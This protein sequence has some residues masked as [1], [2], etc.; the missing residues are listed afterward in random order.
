[1]LKN[2]INNKVLQHELGLLID[3]GFLNILS[4][5]SKDFWGSIES[6]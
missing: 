1:M 2:Q 4:E 5:N 3:A 6:K